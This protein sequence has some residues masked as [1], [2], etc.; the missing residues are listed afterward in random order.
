M[1]ATLRDALGLPVG[2][3]TASGVAAAPPAAGV[4]LTDAE[5]EVLRECADI[6][7]AQLLSAEE[8]GDE[9]TIARWTRRNVLLRGLLSRAA[10]E[11]GR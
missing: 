11:E 2:H 10:K 5:R 4:K 3:A 9:E 8:G 1:W 7:W 6:A